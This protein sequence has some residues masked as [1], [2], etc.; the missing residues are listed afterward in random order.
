MG[1][2]DVKSHCMK[3]Q[4]TMDTGGRVL[5]PR[6]VRDRLGLGPGDV[7]E[8]S[9]GDEQIILEPVRQTF[10]LEKR[11]GF[12]VY[13]GQPQ[14]G[15]GTGETLLAEGREARAAALLAGGTPRKEETRESVL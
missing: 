10:P 11:C 13:T 9:Q 3:T 5:I 4:I 2:V 1:F 6:E 12:W 15:T 7:L 8:L 14:P